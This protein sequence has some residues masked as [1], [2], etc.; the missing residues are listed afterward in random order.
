M[1]LRLKDIST[2]Q[3][4][5]YI[6]TSNVP[7]RHKAQLVSLRNFDDEHNFIEDRNTIEVEEVKEKY[8]IHPN[9]VL[10]ST[11]LRFQAFRIPDNEQQ[12]IAS[13]SFII[14]RIKENA[15]VLPEFLAW[16][17]N[18]PERQRLLESIAQGSGRVPYISREKLADLEIIV[19][20]LE[21]QE[22]IV[23]LFNL[24]KK[25]K[26]IS[27]KILDRKE[28]YLHKIMEKALYKR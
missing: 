1:N 15:K 14:L 25:E 24:M 5:V 26:E 3:P 27:M 21:K 19:P 28:Y 6:R 10:F 12:Y 2:L 18:H 9:D 11:R 13:N 8:F 7:I 20:E 22:L 23:A 17:L 16:F 4:G